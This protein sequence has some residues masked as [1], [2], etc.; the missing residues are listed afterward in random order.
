MKVAADVAA[1]AW[2]GAICPPSPGA[3]AAAQRY[4]NSWG[5]LAAI[6]RAPRWRRAQKECP[7]PCP[8]R[9]SADRQARRSYSCRPLPRPTTMGGRPAAS[10][11]VTAGVVRGRRR[12][13]R[14]R[15]VGEWRHA[16]GRHYGAFFVGTLGPSKLL[17]MVL[18][19]A[20]HRL[21]AE[22]M[23][24]K[25][26]SASPGQTCNNL[27]GEIETTTLRMPTIDQLLWSYFRTT[28]SCTATCIA[29]QQWKKC[30]SDLIGADSSDKITFRAI[31]A[32]DS[33][34]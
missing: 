20:Y 26:V 3:T 24:R 12:R 31:W 15:L 7:P 28:G 30:S 27:R 22:S 13:C 14:L 1:V 10:S 33:D 2:R 4:R 18:S 9:S 8:T 25:D 21:S 5:I 23:I 19:P 29:Q 17:Q 34:C 16:A 6:A 11:F 32:N